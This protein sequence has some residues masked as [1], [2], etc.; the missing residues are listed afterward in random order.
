MKR[1][2]LA[3]A[4]C[5]AATPA[6]ALFDTA[7]PGV[8]QIVDPTAPNTPL[9]TA[10]H[11]LNT[12]ATL[13]GATIGGFQPSAAGSIGTPVSVTTASSAQ[14]LPTG[15]VVIATNVGATNAAFCQLGAA[16]TVNSQLLAPNGGW[17][18]FTVGSATQISCIT[19][20]S[21]TT[22]NTLGGAG[23]ASGT[24]GG[25]GGGSGSG[26]SVGPTGA[27]VPASATYMGML[28]AGNLTGVP[29]TANGVKVD[30]SGVTQPVSIAS[31]PT[32]PVTGTFW[33]A[34]QPVSATSLPLP[35]GAATAA[36]QE[37]TAAGTSASSAQAIQGVTGG[38]PQPTIYGPDTASVTGTITANDT[39]TTTCPTTA[40][41]QTICTGTPTPAA[42]VSTA[43]GPV[44]CLGVS[45]FVTS[46]APT[47]TF[48]T[49]FSGD[50]VNWV[51]RGLFLDGKNAPIWV[52]NITG[53]VFTGQT[54]AGGMKFYRVRATSFSG[55][56]TFTVTINQSQAQCQQ[57]I[58]NL[59][60]AGNGSQS[61][62][63]VNIQGGGASALNVGV[64]EVAQAGATLGAPTAAGVSATG[65]IPPIQG[66][67]GGVPVPISGS[68]TASFSQF[69]PNGNYSTPLVV[70]ATSARTPLPSG[71]GSTVAVYNVG[72]NAAFVILGNTSVIATAADDQVAP[73]GFLCLAV[74][75]NVDIAAIETLGATTLNISGGSGGCAGSG[76]G[77]GGSSSANVFQATNFANS[78][79]AAAATTQ[80]FAASGSTVI[81]L[82]NY[83]FQGQLAAGTFQIVSGTGTNC[84]TSQVNMTPLWDLSVNAAA[85]IGSLGVKGASAAGAALCVKTTST[86]PIS[87]SI[88][89]AQQ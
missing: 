51:P 34:T 80:Q 6:L 22:V 28:V 61:T 18:A 67:T 59:P 64:N 66:V 35:T 73:G 88:G 87:W 74:G 78:S 36:N 58:G 85:D 44:A 53:G 82:V 42:V 19:S 84:A 52:N 2:L 11:P 12:T 40:A 24:G 20:T 30:G 70:G 32:T 31:M 72:V 47:A 10:S 56:G 39:G 3:A 46:G 60:T 62:A 86:N 7:A 57:Y 89:V 5:A 75:A 21:T 4:F 8:V 37:V 33:Q 1:L 15:T 63:S 38:V 27:S 50:N 71:G 81:Y 55:S 79:A 65:N 29:G 17:F 49:E 14:T 68:V 83:S 9:G 13:S 48:S 69:A 26:A 25:G 76:G 54:S 43:V 41:G 23:I 16:A 45:S 77:G